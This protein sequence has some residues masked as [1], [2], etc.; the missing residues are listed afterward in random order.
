MIAMKKKILLYHPWIK[1]RGGCER[2]VK[3][4]A[5]RLKDCDCTILTNYYD[6][7]KT[8]PEFKKLKVNVSE[9]KIKFEGFM[10]RG[11][12]FGLHLLFSKIKDLESYDLMIVSTSGI[13]E[14]I[15]LR[16]HSVPII[17]FCHTTL[18]AAHEFYDYYYDSM[19][20]VKKIFFAIG[21]KFYKILEK[22]SWKHIQN[23]ACHC[24]NVKQKIKNENLLNS[25]NIFV[26]KAGID[27]KNFKPTWKY[28]NYFFV[29]GRFK[30]YKRFELA[31]NAFKEF[32]K[33]TH[34][35]FRLIIAGFPED[36][37]YFDEIQ[38]LAKETDNVKIIKMPSDRVLKQLYQNCYAV[39]FCAKDE[40]FGLVPLEAMACGK[41]VISV[42]EG[43]PKETILNGR[44]DF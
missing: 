4:I 34:E 12:S 6:P 28:K 32:K 7:S 36:K 31:I 5:T 15:T 13:A 16:N 25:K 42:N 30:R 1:S 9:P 41:P 2:T 37:K 39:L 10:G 43:G 24:N 44:Q 29:P 40:D 19:G 35:N 26:I 33:K 22:E 27:T 18:R 38:K 3:E 14:L 11:V 8:F 21:V 17:A 20:P 23:V